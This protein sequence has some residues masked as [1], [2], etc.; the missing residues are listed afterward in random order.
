M[1][2]FVQI[3]DV[4]L[5][6]DPAT[7]HIIYLRN[8]NQV[9]FFPVG[10]CISRNFF[11]SLSWRGE[12][13]YGNVFKICAVANNTERYLIFLPSLFGFLP[14]SKVFARGLLRFP[15]TGPRV[16]WRARI[17]PKIVRFP[18]RK[19]DGSEK[20]KDHHFSG[21]SAGVSSFQ[22]SKS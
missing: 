22:G 11:R 15:G 12:Q 7:L 20:R 9:V 21:N 5:T 4:D 18:D 13:I 8:L 17:L 14:R 1:P 3:F 16:S 2:V 6:I 19:R 10:N